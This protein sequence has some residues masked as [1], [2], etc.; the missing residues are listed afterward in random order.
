MSDL[1]PFMAGYMKPPKE[2]RFKKGKSGNPRGRPKEPETLASITL[3]VLKKKIRI[4]GRDQKVSL[5][6]AFALRLRDLAIQGYQPA[7]DILRDLESQMSINQRSRPPEDYEERVIR[8]MKEAGYL[9]IK[10]EI[11]PIDEFTDE[12]SSDE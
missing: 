1:K 3:K 7:V 6:H 12:E 8:E 9:L 10:G 2:H 5:T 11:I 4:K